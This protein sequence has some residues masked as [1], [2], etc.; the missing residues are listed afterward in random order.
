ME[1]FPYYL[2]LEGIGLRSRLGIG[3][4]GGF[5]II[6]IHLALVAMFGVFLPWTKGL[7]FLD[8][9]MTTAYVSLGVLF[10]APA[11]AQAFAE[12]G[13]PSLKQILARIFVAAVYGEA[14]A[15][16]MLVAGVATVSVTHRRLL[17]PVLDTL[18]SGG[19]LGLSASLA[20]AS[21]AGWVTLRYSAAAARTAMRL[22]FLALLAAFFL[23]SRWLP[24]VAGTGALISLAV[25]AAAL[26]A[27]RRCAESKP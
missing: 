12:G 17:L 20:L 15:V 2:R 22:I 9:V 3:R 23:R 1:T 16:A 24:D 5:R 26:I 11:A 10:A 18:A 21:V 19:A 14:M 8:P 27:L 13:A 4:P 6:A 25:S 7:D